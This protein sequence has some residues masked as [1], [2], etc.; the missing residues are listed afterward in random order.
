MFSI[1]MLLLLIIIMKFLVQEGKVENINDHRKR[2]RSK[3]KKKQ[4][5]LCYFP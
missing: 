3:V 5:H 1:I 2:T 4:A